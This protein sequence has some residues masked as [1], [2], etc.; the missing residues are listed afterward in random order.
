MKRRA[1]LF[2]LGLLAGLTGGYFYLRHRA[3]PPATIPP[4]PAPAVTPATPTTPA[5]TAAPAEVPIQEGKTIDF[6]SGQPEIRATDEDRAAI[7]R[8]AREMDEA[9]KDV[10]FAPTKPAEKK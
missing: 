8:A 2:A 3:P 5:P 9:T 4:A 7:E 10:T 1:L 6:S